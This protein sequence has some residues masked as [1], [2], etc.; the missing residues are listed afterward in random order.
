MTSFKVF[1][2]SHHSLRTALT[3]IVRAM[4]TLNPP[5]SAHLWKTC[6][7]LFRPVEGGSLTVRVAG[8]PGTFEIDSHSDILRRILVSGDY[9]PEAV[10]IV[11][12]M[13][14]PNR[15]AIDVGANIGLFTILISSLLSPSQRVLG[16]EPAPGALQY[17]RRNLASHDRTDDV[18]L[19]E[20][21]AAQYSGE[22][23][24]NIIRG[25]EEYSSLGDIVHPSV[26][27]TAPLRLAVPGDTIDNLT[28]RFGLKPGFI[29]IDAEGAEHQVLSGCEQVISTYRPVF[30][31]ESWPDA[32]TAAAGAI[33][34]AVTNFL[35]ARG[36]RIA[37]CVEGGALAVPVEQRSIRA[38]SF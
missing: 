24:I 25:K 19:F 38:F 30:L 26:K 1:V 32:L 36:Y 6:D 22:F 5:R 23:N 37:A 15:D 34:G 14:D 31:C 8:F 12:K 2:K 3:P 13:V 16:I 20:G 18:L 11:R 29:K 27:G 28:Q 35:K 9:E 10:D 33:P 7:A 4:R 21:V 17:L